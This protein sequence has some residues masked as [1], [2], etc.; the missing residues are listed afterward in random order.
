[1]DHKDGKFYVHSN[2]DAPNYRLI[3]LDPAHPG[4]ENWEIVV[5]ARD[6]L[7]QGV[8]KGGG[9]FLADYLDSATTNVYRYDS[10]GETDTAIDLPG[11]GTAG[12]FNGEPE[13]TVLFYGYTSFTYPTTIFEYDLKTGKSKVFYQP[14]LKFDPA[15]YESKQVMYK[16]KDGTDVSMFIVHKKG[17]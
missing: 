4:K 6:F 11:P 7:L 9:F 15:A 16:S 8:S 13:D 1:I 12:G 17:L 5:P 10:S 14:E 2:M 3:R